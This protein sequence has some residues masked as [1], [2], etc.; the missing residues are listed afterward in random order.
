MATNA[1]R[2][3]MVQQRGTRNKMAHNYMGRQQHKK[4]DTQQIDAAK[5]NESLFGRRQDVHGYNT[6]H[7]KDLNTLKCRLSKSLNSFPIAAVKLY[8][9]LPESIRN[10]NTIK[11]KEAIWSRLTSR[12]IYALKELEDDPL[13]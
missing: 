2:S 9:S 1:I 3:K 10:M 8:N 11:F 13:F 6:H 5:E 7:A 4:T 12:P